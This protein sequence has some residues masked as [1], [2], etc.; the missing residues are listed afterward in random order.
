METPNEHVWIHRRGHDG[1]AKIYHIFFPLGYELSNAPPQSPGKLKAHLHHLRWRDGFPR[2]S[3][4]VP[5]PVE[6]PLI[7]CIQV[8]IFTQRPKLAKANSAGAKEPF[9]GVPVLPGPVFDSSRSAAM[10]LEP[11]SVS[12]VESLLERNFWKRFVWV[13]QPLCCW[14]DPRS[15]S[16][17]MDIE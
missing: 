3:Y 5:P 12:F 1:H 15:Q 9:L 11:P 16:S 10:L 14:L 4:Q 7:A 17:L 6:A 13:R 8:I 2:V